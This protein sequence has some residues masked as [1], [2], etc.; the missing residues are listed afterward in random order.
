M[1]R[2]IAALVLALCGIVGPAAAQQ[3]L[4][5]ARQN[6]PARP[7]GLGPVEIAEML[8][9][10]A[11][12]QAEKQLDLREGQF[13]EFVSRLKTLQ[14]T[15]RRNLHARNLILRELNR[16]TGPKATASDEPALKERLKALREHDDRAAAELRRLY[17]T[18]DEVLEPRQQARF[19]LF[20]EMIERRKF[21][22]VLRA[23]AGAATRP[24]P[25]PQPPR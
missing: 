20:E 15:R 16:L 17:D 18:L 19:R 7:P 12:L 21:E 14:Q 5:A 2:T 22:L 24:G 3:E 1:A 6:R 23:R 13:G 11:L 25:R 8:D 9:A 4:P 10:W